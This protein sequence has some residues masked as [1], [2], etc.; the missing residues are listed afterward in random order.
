MS[1]I[2]VAAGWTIVD[3]VSTGC[4]IG[5]GRVLTGVLVVCCLSVGRVLTGIPVIL[6]AIPHLNCSRLARIT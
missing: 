2:M 5:V 3:R 1:E 6:T 4:S